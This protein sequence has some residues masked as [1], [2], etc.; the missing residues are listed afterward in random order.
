MTSL[1]RMDDVSHVGRGTRRGAPL[2][3]ACSPPRGEFT[4]AAM[5][6]DR[7]RL[8]SVFMPD[9]AL[10]IT[11]TRR[12]AMRPGRSSSST[13]ARSATTL[14]GASAEQRARP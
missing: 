14:T 11:P 8:A 6:R 10:R 5:I 12:T 4:D 3:G 2:A 1:N 9:G 13:T 7:A